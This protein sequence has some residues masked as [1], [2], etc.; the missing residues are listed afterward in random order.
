MLRRVREARPAARVLVLS[1]YPD[2]QYALQLI[3]AGA[4]AYLSRASPPEAPTVAAI[5]RY[6]HRAGLID[7]SV[8]G[9]GPKFFWPGSPWRRG[10][11]R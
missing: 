1:I 8:G 11:L 4:A 5:V 3:H 6:A 9:P 10:A 2:E 7:G